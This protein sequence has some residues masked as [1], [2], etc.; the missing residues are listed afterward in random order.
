[1][2]NS[3]LSRVPAR[4]PARRTGARRAGL[5]VCALAL[6]SS[7][8]S[9]DMAPAYHPTHLL[10]PDDWK[11]DGI[12]R[13][14]APQDA[15][16]R[17]DWWTAFNDPVLNRLEEQANRA[18]PD[19][20]VAAETFT[21]ARDMAAEA[22]AGLYP[23]VAGQ[24][25]MSNN[26]GSAH[27]LWRGAGST[28]PIYM[29][30]EQ[31]GGTASWEP[32]F[33]SSIRNQV[34][35]RRQLAQQ[36]AA[37]YALMRLSLDAELASDY[38]ALR[39]LDAQ[40]TVY[41]DSI[42]TYELAVQI[43]HMRQAGAIAAGLDVARAQNQLY[44]TQAQDTD[45]Q[46]RRAVMEHAI[47]VLVNVSPSVF[48]IEPVAALN[49]PEIAIPAGVPSTLLERRPDV[50][51]AEREM[52]QANRA[53][54]VSRAAF[55]PHVTFSA[56]TGFMDNGFS[57]ADL[58]NSMYTYA[59]QAVMPLF[60]GGLRRAELQRTWSQYRQAED[61]YRS[62]VLSAFQDVEDGLSLTGHLR[63]EQQQQED[64]VKAAL[65]T[66]NMTMTLY[67]GGLTNYLDVVVA[68]IAALTARISEV[69]VET[70]RLQANVTLI[71]ALGG[72]WSRSQLPDSKSIMPFAPLQYD[73]LRTPKTV[74]GI[75][76]GTIP[77]QSDLTGAALRGPGLTPPGK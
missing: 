53:I 58:S 77:E 19:L 26:K 34:R 24:A 51:G 40:D 3:A 21:Q 75:A 46:A 52:A 6:L 39:G 55:Y 62:T 59:A 20:Q 13:F 44:A 67:T 30:S 60:Q 63:V 32:D 64:A 11:G 16:L 18:N 65:R 2:T 57:L 72:G 66:Q 10:F 5:R 23:Q 12:M 43:T 9:C 54:G 1:M 48:H 61:N 56:T 22:R 28:G 41:R 47:A 33:W 8:A 76:A 50:A 49:F 27:R 71:R 7:L 42:R 15:A 14:A 74:G 4:R 73:G 69:Q 17:G 29:S 36:R 31:Y 35:M 25:S 70:R 37:E 45:L 38:L 68:Q